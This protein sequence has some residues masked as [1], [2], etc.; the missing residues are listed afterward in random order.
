MRFFLTNRFIE[1]K[2]ISLTWNTEKVMRRPLWLKLVI[3]I[4]LAAAATW[5]L[6]NPMSMIGNLSPFLFYFAVIFFSACFGGSVSALFATIS[7]CIFTQLFILPWHLEKNHT[8]F[9][10]SI[11][12]F[13]LEGLMLTGLIRIIELIELRMGSERSRLQAIVEKSAE[14]FLTTNEDGII[15]YVCSSVSEIL[16]YTP[17]DLNGTSLYRLVHPNDKQEFE[18]KLMKLLDGKSKSAMFLQKMK[19]KSE[20]WKWIEGCMNN[21]LKDKPVSSIVFNYRNVTERI[22]RLKQQEDFVHMASHELKTPITSIKGF[23]QLLKFKLQKEDR[24]RDLYFIERM[25]KQLD[26]LLA[27][28]DDML[29]MTRI[30]AGEMYYHRDWF[31]FIECVKEVA[32]AVQA[33]TSTHKI[34]LNSIPRQ[35]RIHADRNRISQVITNLVTNAIKYSP[36]ANLVELIVTEDEANVR[37]TVKDYGIG[38]SPDKQQKIFE[39]FYRVDG[40]VKEQVQGLGLGLFIAHEII[41]KHEGE[42]GV[43]SQPGE[44]SEFWFTL[45]AFK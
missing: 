31:N 16:G 27:L 38:I 13:A 19:T 21:L 23:S 2:L 26:R 41:Q 36:D 40:L 22:T 42:M 14:G 29:N 25:E 45:P 7:S 17:G 12:L 43:I 34:R 37:L 39:R 15:T 8:A 30:S 11:M 28:I 20:D 32:E 3:P 18:L 24:P 9:S 33:T 35:V 6:L 44:G 5:V 4:A 1:A 10:L